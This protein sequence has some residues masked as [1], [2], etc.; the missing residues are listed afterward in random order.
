MTE[1]DLLAKWAEERPMYEAWGNHVAHAIVNALGPVIA[2]LST[3]VFLRIPPKARTK[4]D[5]SLLEKAFYRKSYA[6]PYGDITDKVGVRFVVLLRSQLQALQ[7]V[8]ENVGDWSFTKDRD[9]EIEQAEAPQHFD[10]AAVHYVV[11]ASGDILCDGVSVSAG[12]PCEVQIKTILQHAYSELTHDTIYKPQINATPLMRRM[13]AKSMAL[14][15]ATSDYFE[16]VVKQVAEVTAG[17]KRLTE[18]LAE[19]YRKS[20]GREPEVTRTEALLLEAYEPLVPDPMAKVAALLEAKPYVG[21]KISERANNKL[22]FR[23]PSILL[24]YEAVSMAP[25]KARAAWPLTPDEVRPIFSD[26]GLASH[27]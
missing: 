3:G 15:E 25:S 21:A 6:D 8:V 19:V 24:V 14:M 11:R 7:T 27:D 5:G 16:Q 12:T 1:E 13:A 2:P 26:L 20:V 22:L 9:F 17:Q 23:Q 4:A 18:D 10:Y